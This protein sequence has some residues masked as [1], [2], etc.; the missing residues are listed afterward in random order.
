[1]LELIKQRRSIRRYT[2]EPVEESAVGALLEAAMA[3]PSANNRR[4][5]EFVVV[6]EAPLRQA[7]AGIHRWSYMCAQAPVVLA[8]LADPDADPDHWVEDAA[9]ATQNLLLA[10]TAQGLGSVWV[11]VHPRPEREAAVRRILQVPD[12]LRVLCL[13]AVGHPAETRPA[14]RNPYEVAKV[15]GERYGRPWVQS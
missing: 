2:A 6:T 5:W 14:R 13:V 3:A 15:H 7:L 11:A 1:L 9:A 12:R 4:P 10:A 8:V